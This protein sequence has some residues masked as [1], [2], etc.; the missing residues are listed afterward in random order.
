MR[1]G[2]YV[3]F[4]R[5]SVRGLTLIDRLSCRRRRCRALQLR[6]VKSTVHLT[7]KPSAKT[8]QRMIDLLAP[9]KGEVIATTAI[10]SNSRSSSYADLSALGNGG[11][12]GGGESILNGWDAPSYRGELRE[13]DEEGSGGPA[14]EPATDDGYGW[15]DS[16]FGGG[17][18]LGGESA[19]GAAA[20]RGA[21]QKVRRK[22]QGG[23][24]CLGRKRPFLRL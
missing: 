11:G 19:L 17:S 23:G 9:S 24:L 5:P 3:C 12:G 6:R 21:L 16:V 20:R 1:P 4:C 14:T 22:R 13:E 7:G 15:D 2:R 10:A 18:V 8:K